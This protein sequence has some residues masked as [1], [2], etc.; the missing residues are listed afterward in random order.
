TPHDDTK[1]ELINFKEIPYHLIKD[2]SVY[3]Q[4][5]QDKRIFSIYSS[6]GCPYNCSFCSAP[7][8]YLNIRGKKWLCLDVENTVDHIAYLVERYKAD[9]IYFIDNDSFVD[10]KHVENI[11]DEINTRKIHIKLGFRGARINE[12][13]LMTDVFLEK[14]ADAGTDIMHIGAESGSNRILELVHKNC[15]VADII[16]CNVKLARHPRI[17]ASYNFI[18]GLPTETLDDLHA[19]RDL[20]F[21]LV[22]DNPNCIIFAPNKYRP[23]PGT[24]LF[25]L[26]QKQWGYVVPSSLEE[27]SNIEVEGDSCAPWYPKGMKDFCDL[28]LIGSYFIDNKVNKVTSGSTV[29]YKFLRVVNALYGPFIRLRLKYGIY[30]CFWEFRIYRIFV[31]LL[32]KTVNKGSACAND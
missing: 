7:K 4:L 11:I 12:I 1:F 25:E 17:I 16:Q 26:V 24:E 29:F 5:D 15:T 2:Y 13:K 21:R 20:M 19:T 3:G 23:L 27:W 8:E 9:Y 18:V 10:L 28:L 31:K 30:Q 14:L 6:L 32:K 22:K